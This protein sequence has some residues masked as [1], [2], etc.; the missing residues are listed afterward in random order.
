MTSIGFVSSCYMN[1]FLRLRHRCHN[2]TVSSGRLIFII[3]IPHQQVN[4]TVNLLLVEGQ[5]AEILLVSKEP[6]DDEQTFSVF[7]F[8]RLDIKHSDR[9]GKVRWD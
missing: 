8:P 7:T 9:R 6:P 2:E 5:N 4:L 3:I 1:D